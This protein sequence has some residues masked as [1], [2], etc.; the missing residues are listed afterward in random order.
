MKRKRYSHEEK[1]KLCLLFNKE[2]TEKYLLNKDIFQV[3]FN[4]RKLEFLDRKYNI[5]SKLCTENSGRHRPNV[6]SK[7]VYIF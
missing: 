4:L 5:H 6:I 2:I 1:I 7:R 3:T